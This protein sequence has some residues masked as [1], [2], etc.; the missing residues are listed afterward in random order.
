[1]EQQRSSP[2]DLDFASGNGAAY[3]EALRACETLNRAIVEHVAEGNF[4]FEAASKR[5]VQANPAFCRLLCYGEAELIRLTLYDLVAHDPS[6][7]SIRGSGRPGSGR[8][9]GDGIA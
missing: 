3:G 4:L 5:I 7:R 1:M 2:G 6:G 8:P 9:G